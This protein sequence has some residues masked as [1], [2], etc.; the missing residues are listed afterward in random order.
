[1]A[2]KNQRPQDYEPTDRPMTV[3]DV[4][5]LEGG[6]TVF[7]CE[8]GKDGSGKRIECTVAVRGKKKFLTYRDHGT[9]RKCAIV[10]DP[11]KYAYVKVV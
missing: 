4:K 3:E 5:A 9:I 6:S 7:L 10:N 2:R 11:E 8:A 1:M